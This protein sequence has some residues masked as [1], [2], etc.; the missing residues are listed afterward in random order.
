MKMIIIRAAVSIVILCI[1]YA[2]SRL[3]DSLKLPELMVIG[4]IITQ[5][6]NE[7]IS[8]NQTN[9][10]SERFN[11][12]IEEKDKEVI[13]LTEEKDKE[14]NTLKE[15]KDKEINTLKEEKDKEVNNLKGNI[16]SHYG[17]LDKIYESKDLPAKHKN[18]ARKLRLEMLDCITIPI[19]KTELEN[20][21]P[22]G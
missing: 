14:I 11:A 7:I 4:F 19:Y 12:L 5:A 8:Y 13:K 2:A 6:I 22:K 15:E 16:K 18:A 3:A 10:E 20:E 17:S 1:A 9:K 21:K